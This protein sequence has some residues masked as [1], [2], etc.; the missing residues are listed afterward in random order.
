MAA[1]IRR[2]LSYNPYK[3]IPFIDKNNDKKYKDNI[4]NAWKLFVD[5]QNVQNKN[6]HHI[7]NPWETLYKNY[8]L[9]LDNYKS[10]ILENYVDPGK[11]KILQNLETLYFNNATIGIYVHSGKLFTYN[12]TNYDLLE[13]INLDISKTLN[14]MNKYL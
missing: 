10:Y 1:L 12:K 5:G 6:E 9:A 2:M 13:T 8:I 4:I 3:Y 7:C 14:K 11:T